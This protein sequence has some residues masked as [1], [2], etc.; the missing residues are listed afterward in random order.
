LALAMT[1]PMLFST[2]AVGG[3]SPALGADEDELE[4]SA[5]ENSALERSTAGDMDDEIAG[6]EA[7]DLQDPT[8]SQESFLVWL[9]KSLKFRYVVIFLILTF[10]SVAL[11]VMIVLGMRRSSICPDDLAAAF[12]AKLNQ[13]QYQDAYELAKGDKSFLGKVLAAG[14]SK[15]SEGQEAVHDSMQ[16][17]GEE[18]NMK[19]E[20]R[21]GYIALIAQIGPMFGLLGTVD[22]MVMAFDVIAHKS[23]TPK[24]SEL[25]VGIG[26]ALVTTIVGLWIAIPLMVFYH[27]V[28][29]RLARLVI[30]VGVVSGNL[31]KRFDTAPAS[32]RRS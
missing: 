19:M 6:P 18:Q 3:A 22:G 24:P 14:M 30:E 17:V 10:N 5:P 31:M 7:A 2:L 21:N 4:T 20:Q 11:I 26:T 1:A 8:G 29:N 12:E 25:A 16:E 15:I 28:R 23:T 13:K 32:T 9:Y 27:I